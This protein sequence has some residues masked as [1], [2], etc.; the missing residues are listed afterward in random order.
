MV[1]RVVKILGA[2]IGVLLALV[3]IYVL[4]VVISY[5]RI[6]DQQAL[7]PTGDASAEYAEL[8]RTYTV[9]TQNCGFG[10]YSPDFTFFM[11]GGTESWAKSEQDAIANIDMATKEVLSFAPDF[12][13][14]QEVDTD[15]TRSY[16]IDQ[17]AQIAAYFPGFT[18]VF[19]VNYDSPFLA[20]PFTQPHGASNSGLLTFSNTTI[21]SALRRSLT[22]SEGLN[23]FLDLDRCYSVSRI[24][25]NDGKE[26][27]LYNVHTSAYADSDEIRTSQLTQLTQDMLEEYKK[28]NYCICGGDFNH[29]FTGDSTLIFDGTKKVEFGWAQPF[30]AELLPDG[31]SRCIDYNDEEPIPTCRN[32]DVP[33]G[34]DCQVFIVDGFLVSDNV[35]VTALH[36][37]DTG[38]AYSDHNPVVLQFEL[39]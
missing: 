20:Y 32:S 35:S 17:R 24:P 27:V 19:A 8:G 22:I 31:I 28:G 7:E 29:D 12:V 26:L 1:K 36:N 16:H 34:P 6:A 23:K 18:Q 11:D 30:P 5:N 25:T 15:S 38:F 10:A 2:L 33:Y 37:I 3:L 4:Y 9:V 21:T 39:S 13:L 14:L